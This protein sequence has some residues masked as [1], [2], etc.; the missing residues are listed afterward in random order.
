MLHGLGMETR[1]D[2]KR[3]VGIGRWICGVL[4]REPASKVNKAFKA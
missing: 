4:G 2:L 1:V 3:L